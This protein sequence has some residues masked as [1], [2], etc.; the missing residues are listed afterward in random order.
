[1]PSENIQLKTNDE[2]E[3]LAQAF[4]AEDQDKIDWYCGRLYSKLLTILDKEK[5]KSEYQYGLNIVVNEHEIIDETFC[6]LYSILYSDIKNKA[7]YIS[8]TLRNIYLNRVNHNLDP[9]NELNPEVYKSYINQINLHKEGQVELP[10]RVIRNINKSLT[11][12]RKKWKI[13]KSSQDKTRYNPSKTENDILNQIDQKRPGTHIRLETR[14]K[15]IRKTFRHCLKKLTSKQRIAFLI[16]RKT[17]K[18]KHT[19]QKIGTSDSN[20]RQLLDKAEPK[21]SECFRSFGFS[22]KDLNNEL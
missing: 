22:K 18:L 6:V 21:M 4:E 10:D 14:R 17:K 19:A 11:R 8:R 13:H 5:Q 7:S 12:I 9:D 16:H 2:I 1:M 20:I 3:L 15:K